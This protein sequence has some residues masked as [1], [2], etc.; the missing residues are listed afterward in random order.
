MSRI[1]GARRGCKDVFNAYLVENASYDGF[2]EI[3]TIE[4]GIYK[5]RKLISFSKCLSSTDYECWI[6]FYE[7]DVA[8]ERIW[9]NPKKYLPVLK[10]YAGVITPDFSLYRDMPLV[11]QFWNIYRSR[12]IG[13]WLQN[14]GVNVITNIRFG[15]KRTYKCSCMGVSKGGT[16]SIGTHGC[17]KIK[18]EKEYLKEGIEYIVPFLQ[19]KIIIIYGTAPDDIFEKY[20][21]CGIEILQFDSEFAISRKEDDHGSR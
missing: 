18:K 5:P 10:K 8:F 15:D 3:P 2:L 7:D 4:Y 9:N 6:H 21:E 17:V 14:S 12:A 16:I 1:N 11:M 13:S 19:P 20:R